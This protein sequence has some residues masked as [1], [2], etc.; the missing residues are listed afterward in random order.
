MKPQDI[1]YKNIDEKSKLIT[2]NLGNKIDNGVR[3]LVV[4]LNYHK[5][6]TTQSCWGHKN[7]GLPYPWVDIHKKYLG[8]ILEI[9][10]GMDIETENLEETIRIQ[11][12]IKTL[13]KGREVFKGLKNKLK[14]NIK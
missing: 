12:K 4:L 3:E 5:I 13:K 14:N 8:N 1:R 2:D 10:E 7:W 6:G 11:P 9:I